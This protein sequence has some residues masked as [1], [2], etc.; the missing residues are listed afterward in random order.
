[1]RTITTE[2]AVIILIGFLLTIAGIYLNFQN[3]EQIQRKNVQVEVVYNNEMIYTM[4][5]VIGIALVGVGAT[6]GLLKRSDLM[7][8]KFV[9][10]MDVYSSLIKKQMEVIDSAE[11]KNDLAEIDERSK[12]FKEEMK[13][14]KRL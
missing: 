9:N 14:L 4:I 13:T 11:C 6:R 5:A 1:M 8:N 10:I 7:A 3:L 12:K 2:V